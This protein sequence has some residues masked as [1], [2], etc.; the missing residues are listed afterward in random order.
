[1][2][3]DRF[4]FVRMNDSSR[5]RLRSIVGRIGA[6]DLDRVVDNGWTVKVHLAHLAYTDRQM[7]G[8]LKTWEDAG[9][10][11]SDELRDWERGFL[12]AEPPNYNEV[13][14]P[15]WGAADPDQVRGEVLDV[16]AKLDQRI[17]SLDERLVTAILRTSLFGRRR[18]FVLDRSIHRDEHLDQIERALGPNLVGLDHLQVAI[19]PGGE[20][21]ARAFYG[22]LLGVE[23]IP[24]PENL[25]KR[26]GVW[27]RCGR[28]E[29]HLG[30]Q[31]DF[32]PATKAHLAFE[33]RDLESLR[34]RLDENGV[35]IV[36]DEPLEGA[37]RF[38]VADPFGNRLEFLH[39]LAV[40]ER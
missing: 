38:Y 40:G 34:R 12:A 11:R 14:V 37:V 26:G 23:E 18:P 2:T 28:Q 22:T 21:R 16:A 15:E 17:E 27:F 6:E 31:A 9:V 13:R 30:V 25:Q 19:P 32:R 10:S 4:Y 35:P 5:E 29:V 36:E 3:E 24:K 20:D 33:V 8:W 39:H 1:M 7:L